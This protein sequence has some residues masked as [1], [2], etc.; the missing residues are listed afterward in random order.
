MVIVGASASLAASV[1]GTVIGRNIGVMALAS[2]I[3]GSVTGA[4]FFSAS[5]AIVYSSFLANE[6]DCTMIGIRE[7]VV[8]PLLV[9]TLETPQY[10]RRRQEIEGVGRVGS[11]DT[12]HPHRLSWSEMRMHKLLDSTI[13]GALTGGILYSWQRACILSL[14]L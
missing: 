9:S 8:S 3:R 7:F 1:Y 6:D 10:V 13:S 5:S 12:Q 11:S 2:A 4:T 14:I